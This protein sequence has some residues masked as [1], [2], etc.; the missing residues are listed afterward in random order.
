[1]I[2]KFKKQVDYW[3]KSAEKNFQAAQVLFDNRHY[4]SCLFFCHLALEKMLKG[5]VVMAT[6]KEAP[7]I[8]DLVK[9]ANLVDLKLEEKSVKL[10][11]IITTFNIAGRY[12]EEKLAFY[13]RCTKDYTLKYFD[14][15][16]KLFLWLKKEYS[17]K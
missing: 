9:L 3:R 13:K 15:S 1:M 12:Q 8:H 2:V 14:I 10:L 6:K 17:K 11:R 5:L 7:Y 4:D 16:K